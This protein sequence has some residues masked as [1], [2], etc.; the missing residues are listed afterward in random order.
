M[1]PLAYGNVVL[2]KIYARHGSSFSSYNLP[3]VAPSGKTTGSP[4]NKEEEVSILE[5]D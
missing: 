4:E 3:K 2:E 1:S 5:G